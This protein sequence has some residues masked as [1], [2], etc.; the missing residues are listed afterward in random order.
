MRVKMSKQPPPTPTASAVGLALLSAKL[1]G[2]PG[3][4]SVPSTIT[5]P[6]HPQQ[7]EKKDENKLYCY[8]IIRL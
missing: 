2:R 4:E 5:P 7:P 3:T 8:I 1:E 6:N